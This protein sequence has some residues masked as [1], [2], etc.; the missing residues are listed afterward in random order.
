MATTATAAPVP[1]IANGQIRG[2]RPGDGEPHDTEV[3][4]TDPASLP[5]LIAVVRKAQVVHAA[6][7]VEERARMLLAF[8]DAIMRR[9]E[10][11]AN[12]LME[13]T[14]KPEA[15][16]WLHEVVPTADL[17][18]F[19]SVEGMEYL[20]AEEVPLSMLDYPGKRAVIEIVARGVIGLITPWNFPV[21][22]PL[23]TMFPALLA[24]NGIVLKPSEYAPRSGELLAEAAKE[25]YG[26]DLVRVVQGGGAVGSALIGAGV[27]AVVFTGSPRTG[28]LVAAA[29]A[30]ALVPVSLEL[31]GK[32]AAI[33][34]DDANLE[35]AA[36]GI[37]WGA[38]S[39]AGQSCASIER[40]I[41][42]KGIAGRL[43]DRM[44]TLCNELV[45]GRDF[46][47]LTNAAQLDIVEEHVARAVA[48]GAEVLTGGKRLDRPGYWYAP[49]VLRGLDTGATVVTDETF[50]PVVP[51]LVVDDA[52]QAVEVANQ[53]RYG[54]TASVWTRKLGK[55][56]ALA[57]RLRAGVTTVNNHAFS[58]AVP[59]LP[60]TG[61]GE[62]GF[63]V[64]NSRHA[65]EI[66]TRPRAV[67][68]DGSR[69][70]RELWWHPYTPGLVRVGR[71]MT[72]L[73]HGSGPL[74]KLRA[75]FALLGGFLKRWKV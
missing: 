42:T 59:A 20:A 72:T 31:G 4:C 5:D 50:G 39:N 26:P 57:R 51:I 16:A 65:L 55:G 52:E 13:E 34:L 48:A 70:K 9:G 37:V 60:W 40:V 75:F 47:P 18:K 10:A 24:G 7:E 36:R 71:A 58:A 17:G 27:D 74:R 54:L 19:W 41:A 68:V 45:P 64:T 3:P 56:E 23:R 43:A 12:V 22:T 66:M 46:G 73:R 38:I 69:G 11:L 15:E 33:V 2:M 35:R 32:D 61:V 8:R 67:V 49:T 6:R 30:A 21:A 25:V 1:V 14:G 62:S 28:R 29:G 63:G 53:S 44:T